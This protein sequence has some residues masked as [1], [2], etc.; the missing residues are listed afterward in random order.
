MDPL[1]SGS[2]VKNVE[3]SLLAMSTQLT[4]SASLSVVLCF[5]HSHTHLGLAP[6][7]ILHGFDPLV[8]AD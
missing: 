5:V 3:K 4:V 6:V 8:I 7:S 2:M 1:S